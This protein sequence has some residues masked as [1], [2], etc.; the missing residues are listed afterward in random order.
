[1]KMLDH[2]PALLSLSPDATFIVDADG[3]ILFASEQTTSLLGYQPDELLGQSVEVLIP[4]TFA[5]GHP[6]VRRDYIGAPALR[7]MGRGRDLF[8][9]TKEKREIPVEVSLSPIETSEGLVVSAALRDVSYRVEYEQALKS[10]RDVAEQANRAK[11]RF[12]AAASHDLRQP[13]Q[14]L[15]AYLAVLKHQI[16]GDAFQSVADKMDLSL[17]A[18]GSLLDAL[19]DISQLES[20]SIEPRWSNF[21]LQSLLDKVLASNRPAAERKGLSLSSVPTNLIVRS[22]EALLARIIDNFVSNAIRYTE[23]GG[24]SIKCCTQS[25]MVSIKISDTGIGIPEEQVAHIFEEYYQLNNPARERGKGLGLGLAIVKR[26]ADLLGHDINVISTDAAG[27]EFS[28]DVPLAD[29]VSV[30]AKPEARETRADFNQDRISLLLVDDDAAVR[31]SMKLLLG[32]SGF[33]IAVAKDPVEALALIDSGKDPQVLISDYRLPI[34][35][36]V[37]LV[38]RVR[39]TSN[40]DIPVVLM[41]GDTSAKHIR[42]A[43]LDNCHIVHKPTNTK[44][45]IDLIRTLA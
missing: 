38:N 25:D 4:A 1:M 39:A 17:N 43:G 5:A 24:V 6:E 13:L 3:I 19:L 40:V 22:D 35:N 33:D 20:G 15:S 23:S 30:A 28:V 45:L 8:A 34:M 21:G 14:S 2:A 36:G 7:P 9:L 42:A 31:D 29:A 16:E 41:T 18:M 12:L 26:I 11:S 44:A 27:S 32:L 10:A 37:E